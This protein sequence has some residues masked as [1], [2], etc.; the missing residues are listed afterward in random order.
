MEWRP[1][2]IKG[3]PSV[4]EVSEYGDI[5]NTITGI[6]RKPHKNRKGYL[7]IG[8]SDINKK[9]SGLFI[10]RIVATAFIPNPNNCPQVNHIDCDKT[11]NH[12]SNLEWCTNDEN[13]RHAMEHDLRAHMPGEQ[14]PFSKYK[15]EQIRKVCEL[16]VEGKMTHRDISET[17][18][19]HKRTVDEIAL[20]NKWVYISKE[21]NLPEQK[22][23][24]HNLSKYKKKIDKLLKKGYKWQEIIDRVNIPDISVEQYRSFIYRRKSKLKQKKDVLRLSIYL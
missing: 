9:I 23:H 12:F 16:L 19:V 4:Y 13:M 8:L 1:V 11:N 14:N 18:G 20:K 15:E 3:V 6:F 2:F 10:H 7:H 5:R 21:Y 17:T 22:F 24:K